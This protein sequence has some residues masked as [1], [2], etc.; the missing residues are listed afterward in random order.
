MKEM[1]VRD[2]VWMCAWSE[3]SERDWVLG[4]LA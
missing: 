1:G 4:G 2:L 3:A